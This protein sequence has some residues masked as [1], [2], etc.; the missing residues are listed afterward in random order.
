M[1]KNSPLHL[2]QALAEMEGQG[3]PALHFQGT[4]GLRCST[5]RKTPPGSILSLGSG[6]VSCCKTL[7]QTAFLELKAEICYLQPQ[8][9]VMINNVRRKIEQEKQEAN[10]KVVPGGNVSHQKCLVRISCDC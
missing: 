6:E 8:G 2:L 4:H 9:K 7:Q 10:D 3:L 1:K 5:R